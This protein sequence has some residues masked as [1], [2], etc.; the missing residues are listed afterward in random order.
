MSLR[1]RIEAAVARFIPDPARRVPAEP[2]LFA[3]MRRIAALDEGLEAIYAVTGELSGEQFNLF[4]PALFI[5]VNAGTEDSDELAALTWFGADYASGFFG[6]DTQ[7][8]IG[9]GEG[10][11]FWADRAVMEA[12]ALVPAGENLA[13]FLEQLHAGLR[14]GTGP[15]LGDR[16]KARMLAALDRLPES[17]ERGPPIAY[18]AFTEARGERGLIVTWALADL[19]LKANG[20]L[21]SPQRQIWP[22]ERMTMIVEGGAVAIGEDAALG[23]LAVTLGSWQALPA[24]RMFAFTP[25]TAPEN[26]RLLGRTADVLTRWIEEASQ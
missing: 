23:T 16:A 4:E 6:V 18:S 24:D 7:G 3:E 11:V 12:D 19:L 17:I 15:S 13:D 5:D 21:L 10:A 25:G 22:F 2:D 20:L 14:P 1:E 26:G 8:V 9:L